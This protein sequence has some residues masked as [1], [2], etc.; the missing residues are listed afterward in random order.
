MQPGLKSVL[1]LVA[2]KVVTSNIVLATLGMPVP[3]A[4]RSKH[5]LRYWIPFTEAA[6][7][8]GVGFELITPAAVGSFLLSF[9]ISNLVATHVATDNAGLQTAAALFTGTGANAGNYLAVIECDIVVGTTGGTLD[10]QVAQKVSDAGA[11]TFLAGAWVE[12]TIVS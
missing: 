12:D 5:H 7:A 10:L 6:G 4:A 1:R 2:N 8:A 9:F 11:T 3:A